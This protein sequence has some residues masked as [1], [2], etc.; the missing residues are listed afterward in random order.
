[1]TSEDGERD[2][3]AD[4]AIATASTA[5]SIDSDRG[6]A[7]P[8]SQAPDDAAGIPYELDVYAGL[9]ETLLARGYEFVGFDGAIEDGQIALRHD[10]DLSLSR[11]AEMA[12]VEAALGIESTYCLQVTAPLYD[13]LVPENRRHV[14]TIV[15]AGH[16][17]GLHFDPHYYWESEPVV[18]DLELRVLDDRSALSRVIADDFHRSVSVV[19]T[20]IHQPPNWALGATFEA[21]QSTYEPRYFLDVEY[22][23]DSAGKWRV[24]RPFE[25]EVP[26]AMQLLVHP[27]LWHRE[28][29]SL[30]AILEDHREQCRERIDR[31]V[32]AFGG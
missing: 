8:W 13:L 15:E 30:A 25:D 21:F 23:S 4:P 20:S 14:R 11:A 31:Y 22:V 2:G 3:R 26:D 17:V 7:D 19:A 12:R 24:Q 6:T 27:G 28:D 5:R 10:V 9:L 16:D 32:G 1:M 18:D 29:H